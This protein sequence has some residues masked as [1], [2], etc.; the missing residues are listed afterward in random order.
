MWIVLTRCA[1]NQGWITSL[2]MTL[3]QMCFITVMLYFLIQIQKL[4]RV[5][6]RLETL[7]CK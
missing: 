4:N 1:I 3:L 5:C 2:I 7:S 6:L